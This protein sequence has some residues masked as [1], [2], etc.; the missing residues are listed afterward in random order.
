MREAAC[1]SPCEA[2]SRRP[3]GT[4]V[5]TETRDGFVRVEI[6]DDGRGFDV[7][8]SAD[9]RGLGYQ[10]RRAEAIGGTIELGS[11][12]DGTILTLLLPVDDRGDRAETEQ[13]QAGS[14][15]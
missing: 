13:R 5:T 9:G 8:A 7:A 2:S 14:S 11:G 3:C 4:R 15:L 12:P 1:R 6:I 10:A